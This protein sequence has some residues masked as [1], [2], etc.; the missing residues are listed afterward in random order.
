[1]AGAAE[2]EPEVAIAGSSVK[3]AHGQRRSEKKV[4]WRPAMKTAVAQCNGGGTSRHWL[5][6]SL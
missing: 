1:V 3:S 6:P 4:Q 2:E 5:R